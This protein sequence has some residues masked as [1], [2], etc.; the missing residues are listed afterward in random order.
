MDPRPLILWRR[1][2]D[3]LRSDCGRAAVS[4][5]ERAGRLSFVLW[6]EGEHAGEFPNVLAAIDAG[7]DMLRALDAAERE[8]IRESANPAR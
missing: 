3:E 7:E 4:M 6:R 1:D 2:G 8:E 5:H